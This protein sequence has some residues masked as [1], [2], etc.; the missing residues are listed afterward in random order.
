MPA[1]HCVGRPRLRDRG[2]KRALCAMWQGDDRIAIPCADVA[3]TPELML[4]SVSCDRHRRVSDPMI[5]VGIPLRTE[6]VDLHISDRVGT[7]TCFRGNSAEGY[8]PARR[9]ENLFHIRR[10]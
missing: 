1:R 7:V 3:G 10:Q 6:I 2:D 9:S 4:A 8:I 5:S